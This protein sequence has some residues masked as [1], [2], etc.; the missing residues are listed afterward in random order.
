MNKDAMKRLTAAILSRQIETGEF[1]VLSEKRLR[2]A[3][4][5]GPEFTNKERA[6]LMLSPVTRDDWKRIR[7]EVLDEIFDR[8]EELNLEQELVPLAASGRSDESQINL[9]GSGFSLTLFRQDNPETPWVILVQLDAKYQN[10]IY[11]M[12]ELRLVD[13]G[14]LE[15]MRG[16]PDSEGEMTGV[17][18]E[19]SIDLLERSTRYTLKLMPV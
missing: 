18:E 17:W 1:E 12:T 10:V 11:P 9:S 19:A 15:W 7:L 3:M 4:T 2:E 6:L 14:G 13:S 5:T 8:C 16:R